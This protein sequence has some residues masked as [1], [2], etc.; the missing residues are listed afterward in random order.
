MA[1]AASV[2][3]LIGQYSDSERLRALLDIFLD[4]LRLRALPAIEQIEIYRDLDEAEGV[5]LDYIAKIV[6]VSRPST[7]DPARDR[8]FGFDTAGEPFDSD[9]F[10]GSEESAARYPLP[11]DVFRRFVQSRALL[12]FGDGTVSTFER[13]VQFIDPDAS[14]T[15]NR[16]MSVTVTTSR[17]D[18]IELADSI[19]ALPRTAGVEMLFALP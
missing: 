17:R 8:R 3:L 16:N 10:R 11:D 19:E 18:L 2:D 6:G 5:F 4:P 12:I 1:L 13:A 9:P 7:T 14:V 15:D